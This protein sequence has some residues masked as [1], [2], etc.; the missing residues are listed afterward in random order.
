MC[1]GDED[2]IFEKQIVNIYKGM[3]YT[4][5]DDNGTAFYFTAKDFNGLI[6]EPYLFKSSK[7]HKL[8]GYLYSYENP[9]ENRI[10]V[11]DHGFGAGHTAYMKEIEIL[12]RH[13]YL[14]FAYDHTGCME[15]GGE[16]P[17]GMAQSLCD[18]NDCI[19]TLKSDK[20]FAEYDFSV[21][22]H[23]WGGFST[24]NISALHSDISHIVV[25]SG[26]VSVNMIVNAYFG[27]ILKPYRKAIMELENSSNPKFNKYNAIETLSKFNGKALLIYSDN[28]M[29]CSKK[30]HYDTLIN[31]L[32]GKNNI[33]FLL[34]HNKGHNPN[35]TLDAVAHLNEY[36]NA[37]NK[38]T[39]Q[40][41]LVTKDQKAEFL[42]SFDWDRMTKQD[43][44]VWNKI[45]ECLDSKI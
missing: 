29:L 36:I 41:K 18:L 20:R 23:S 30:V 37:K 12:C 8:S 4:R 17:N 35:Y 19:N 39:K 40:K 10:I 14:V 38:L 6:C 26:F 22:G 15:S 7:G 2:M 13:G 42:S 11:F 25:L 31:A 9:I 34:E 32:D 3:A 43:E 21:M 28:D 24:L 16:S 45:F 44:N 1:I 27:G 33:E 5:C